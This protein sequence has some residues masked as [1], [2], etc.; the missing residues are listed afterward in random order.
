MLKVD[1]YLSE[2]SR[3]DQQQVE[4]PEIVGGAV[5]KQLLT[6]N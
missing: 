2:M 5:L 3:S 6:G 1:E 4:M